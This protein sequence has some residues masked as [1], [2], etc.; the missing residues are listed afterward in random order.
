MP[1]VSKNKL[2]QR[3]EAELLKNLNLVMTQI[4]NSDDMVMFL[5]ALLTDT[6]KLMLAKRIAIIVLLEE[7]LPDSQIASIL[8]V[9][10]VT[11]AKM[12]Y[13]YDSRGRGL[14]IAVNKLEEQKQLEGFKKFLTS[15]ARYSARA[16][17]GRV[18]PTIL[19]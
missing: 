18:K 12:R 19:D 16:A 8:H 14:K 2:P 5:Q 6:E 15:L 1:F 7:K 9:T 4:H 10:R 3:T 13:F 11:V 17:G